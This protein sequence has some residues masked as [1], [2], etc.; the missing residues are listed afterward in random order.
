MREGEC[1]PRALDLEKKS[2]WWEDNRVRCEDSPPDTVEGSVPAGVAR[3]KV[4]KNE[5]KQVSSLERQQTVPGSLPIAVAS[6]RR[7]ALLSVILTRG[8][9]SYLENTSKDM[10]PAAG[11]E[12]PTQ[13]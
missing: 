13:G 6:A 3:R 4:R 8:V 12:V 2:R 1:D 10:Y 7:G 11:S 9:L 5:Q